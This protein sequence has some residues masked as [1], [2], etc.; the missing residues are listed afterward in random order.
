MSVCI[1][2]FVI[3]VFLMVKAHK[4]RCKEI[5]RKA[6]ELQEQLNRSVKN[7]KNLS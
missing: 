5:D 4:E 2:L 3:V 6:R 7:S 1:A